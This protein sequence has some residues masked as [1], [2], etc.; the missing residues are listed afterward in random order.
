MKR[1][2]GK[3][4]PGIRIEGSAQSQ[5]QI[6][7]SRSAVST[8]AVRN[9]KG[10]V[11]DAHYQPLGCAEEVITKANTSPGFGKSPDLLAIA[12]WPPL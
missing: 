10:A 11:Y 4:F 1:V 9:F 8:E 3:I 12:G 6:R 7:A 5:T 2:L